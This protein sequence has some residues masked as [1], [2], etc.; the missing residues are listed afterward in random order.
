[1]GAAVSETALNVDAR[2]RRLRKPRRLELR[3]SIDIEVFQ[4]AEDMLKA[5]SKNIGVHVLPSSRARVAATV[6]N[7]LV[8]EI[9]SSQRQLEK[10]LIDAVMTRP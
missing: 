1:M 2:L 5:A 10:W 7:L 8:L 9:I 4:H 6:Y 3:R